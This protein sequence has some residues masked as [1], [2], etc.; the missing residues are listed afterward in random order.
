MIGIILPLLAALAFSF[1]VIL[2]KKSD[3]AVPIPTAFT[4]TLIGF[5]IFWPI[6]ILFTNLEAINLEALV[7]FAVAGILHPGIG[8]LLYY[9][10]MDVVGVSVNASVFATYP[11]YSSILAVL[12]L[13]DALTPENWLGIIC[14][15][16]G[17]VLIGRVLGGDQ[18]E[19]KATLRSGLIFP[20]LASLIVAIGHVVR[21]QGLN[22]NNEPLLG[23]SVGYSLS[24]LLYL[25]LAFL[26]RN[27]RRSISLS[28]DF[29]LFW[30]AGV[31]MSLGWILYFYGLSQERVSIVTSLKETE[32]LF[33]L[34]LT[35]AYLKES[36][37]L[38][39]KLVLSTILVVAGILLVSFF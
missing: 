30:K 3:E 24:L 21:K 9:R 14:I 8:R 39:I 27:V 16:I 28:R 36:E 19:S 5:A 29:R 11:M 23:V 34:L 15:V 31:C 26:S 35:F 7:Y 38:S 33:V 17:V 32:P 22:I 25:L 2:I 18:T 13:G 20:L 6:T 37:P 4:I 1:A 12:F 10:G